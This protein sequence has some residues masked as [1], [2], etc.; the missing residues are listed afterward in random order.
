MTKPIYSRAHPGKY[1]LVLDTETTGSTFGSYEETFSKYQA[2]QFGAIV[3]DSQTFEEVD[4]VEFLVKFDPKYEWTEGA[5][6]IHGITRLRLAEEGL[7]DEDAALILGEFILKYFGTGKVMFLGHN[8]WFDIEAMRQ[9]LEKYKVM[10]DLHHVVLDTSAL[11]WITC[12]KYR[13]NDLFEYFL[14]GRA[15]KHG[16]LDDARMTLTVARSVRQ[17]MN[18]ALAGV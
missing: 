16:A 11:G 17:L 7:A 3:A 8:P 9:L 5:E 13:S 14:G 1:I 18:M 6:K 10:P 2:I 15:E 12:G 4:S